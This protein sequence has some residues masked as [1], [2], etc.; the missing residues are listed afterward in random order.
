MN[1]QTVYSKLNTF[2]E[3]S[4]RYFHS[5][6]GILAHKEGVLHQENMHGNKF[7]YEDWLGWSI[8]V[9]EDLSRVNV[10]DLLSR[11]QK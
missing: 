6:P 1:Q 2:P 10:V 11:V 5:H 4:K 8:L 7:A 9:V 3:M